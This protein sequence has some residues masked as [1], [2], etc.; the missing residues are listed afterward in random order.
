MMNPK[1]LKPLDSVN[2]LL[3]G[4]ED[5][6]M[7]IEMALGYSPSEFKGLQTDAQ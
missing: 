7:V 5:K 2:Q 1:L 4:E 3:H 6:P